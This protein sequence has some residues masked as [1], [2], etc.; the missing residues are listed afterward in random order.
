MVEQ[1][2]AVGPTTP[3][4]DPRVLD[5]VF[6]ALADPTRREMLQRLAAGE[7]TI[8]EL[9][10]PCAMS[11]AAASKHVRVLEKAGL[12]RRTVRGRSHHCRLEAARL[13]EAQ[14]WLAFYQRFWAERFDA[15]DSLLLPRRQHDDGGK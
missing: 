10:E 6:R 14:H 13:A 1:P 15:L 11:F 4:P 12:V 8:T 9:A 5:G 2:A 7:R 3:P